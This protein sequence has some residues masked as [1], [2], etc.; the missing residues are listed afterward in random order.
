LRSVHLLSGHQ[1]PETHFGKLFDNLRRL[2]G[3]TLSAVEGVSAL[4]KSQAQAKDL[5]PNSLF[6]NIVHISHL[7]SILWSLNGM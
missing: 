1:P 3:V 6:R 5:A 4:P 2:A 7:E